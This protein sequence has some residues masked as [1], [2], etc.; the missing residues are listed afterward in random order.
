MQESNHAKCI[1]GLSKFQ[2]DNIEVDKLVARLEA[3]KADARRIL[4][5]RLDT[6]ASTEEEPHR[7][8]VARVANKDACRAVVVDSMGSDKAATAFSE[9]I[10]PRLSGAGIP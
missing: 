5:D 8:V 1:E 6:K 4:A 3:V 2:Q 7:R 10:A 9:H